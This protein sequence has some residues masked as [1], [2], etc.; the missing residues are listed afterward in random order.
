MMD[1]PRQRLP[2]IHDLGHY[3]RVPLSA[4]L[5][6]DGLPAD[7]GPD[8]DIPTVHLLGLTVLRPVAHGKLRILWADA[9]SLTGHYHSRRS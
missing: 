3:L 1:H 9:L 6:H 7:L 2:L 4:V 8:I 5:E